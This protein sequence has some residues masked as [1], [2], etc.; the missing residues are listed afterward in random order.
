MMIAYTCD[1]CGAAINA[2]RP[3]RFTVPEWAG[4]G[5]RSVLL[6]KRGGSYDYDLCDGC[7]R[8]LVEWMKDQR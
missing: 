7:M 3:H 8:D 2:N 1:R 5:W 6:C 4:G